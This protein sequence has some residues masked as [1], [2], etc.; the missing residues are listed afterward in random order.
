MDIQRPMTPDERFQQ[1]IAKRNQQAAN[2]KALQE[3]S[4]LERQSA[5]Q[6]AVLESQDLD[7]EKEVMK[8][9]AAESMMESASKD[10]IRKA[11][12]EAL[13][14][15]KAD[16]MRM[17][18]D[19]V[20]FEM[21]YEGLWVDDEVKQGEIKPMFECYKDTVNFLHKTCPKAFE[22]PK[23]PITAGIDTVI[24]ETVDIACK[25]INAVF[26]DAASANDY[27]DELLAKLRFNLT[28]DEE[29]KMDEKLS[30]LGQ[31][32]IVDLV[33]K[34]VISV[35]QDEKKR[36][37]K[38]AELFEELDAATKDEEEPVAEEDEPASDDKG[39]DTSLDAEKGQDNTGD[40]SAEDSSAE[41]SV[42]YTEED[43]EVEEA[44]K[45]KLFWWKKMR[46]KNRRKGNTESTNVAFEAAVMARQ[47][48]KMNLTG[49]TSVF[50][51]LVMFN[52][53][54]AEYEIVQESVIGNAAVDEASIPQMI[55]SASIM[56]SLMQ[57][58]VMETLNTVRY[59]NLNSTDI[60]RIRT[61]L[62]RMSSKLINTDSATMENLD[63]TLCGQL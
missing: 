4:R 59:C 26:E 29:A 14:N 5:Q 40:E 38:K 27:Q 15:L 13:H 55:A 21:V 44:A 2:L 7:T 17:V 19:K 24:E 42:D 45:S 54:I 49:A 51:G 28:A 16:G 62:N 43:D 53:K 20:L 3:S 58:T 60:N 30:D 50:E 41:E 52:R 48:Q 12:M 61:S 11:A 25:R 56:Q 36:G 31:G 33:K 32:Q 18:R 9:I 47:I 6:T 34:K 1:A 57:Y 23:N 46:N 63:L 35:V 8:E 39:A 37:E 22:I 10:R